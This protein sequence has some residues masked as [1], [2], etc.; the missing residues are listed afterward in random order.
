MG[1]KDDA[2]ATEREG[3][4]AD[5]YRVVRRQIE[6]KYPNPRPTWR[7]VGGEERPG[8]QET[9]RRGIRP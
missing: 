4:M 9:R 2:E 1:L 5:R 7:P 8:E 6:Q 3:P